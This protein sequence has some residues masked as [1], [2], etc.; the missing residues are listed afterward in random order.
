MNEMSDGDVVIAIGIERET[1]SDYILIASFLFIR[2]IH[3]SMNWSEAEMI[4]G[5]NRYNS[6]LSVFRY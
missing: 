6:R 5:V 4:F 2:L 1:V 3:E